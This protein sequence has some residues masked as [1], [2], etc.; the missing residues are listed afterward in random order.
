M[1]TKEKNNLIF[2]RLFPGEEI[3]KNLKEA[4]KKH[5]L[6]TG[7][8]LSG[9]GQVKNIE[10]GY[11]KEKGNYTP[12]SFEESFELLSLNGNIIKDD[13]YNFHL[14]AVLGNEDKKSIG[15][16]LIK[17]QISVTGEIVILKTNLQLKRKKEEETGLDGLYLN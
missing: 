10:L 9:I 13:D 7:V 4:C 5:S 8:I 1:K 16:H 17:A 14:H 6:Q 15:G 2:I 11:F 12:Q 3:Y